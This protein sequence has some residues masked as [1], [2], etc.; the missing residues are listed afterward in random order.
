MAEPLYSA[1]P[2]GQFLTVELDTLTAL[3][4]KRSGA[5]HILAPPAPQ[6]LEA[7]RRGPAD[8]ATVMNRMREAYALVEQDAD[9]MSA[10]GARLDELEGAGLISRV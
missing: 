1:D 7:L 10:L 4:H 2:P 8:A 3:F 5:T 9:D 6:I